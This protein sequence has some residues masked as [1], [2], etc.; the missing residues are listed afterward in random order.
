MPK[1]DLPL[2]DKG[3]FNGS[4]EVQSFTKGISLR[5][6]NRSV[7][8]T[9]ELEKEPLKLYM[10]A[11]AERSFTVMPKL[12]I[13]LNDFSLSKEFKPN[14]EIT[15]GNSVFSTIIYDISPF[16]KK[17]RNELNF[18]R[19]SN[20]SMNIINVTVVSFYKDDDLKT[21]YKLNAGTVMLGNRETMELEN[22][23]KGILVLGGKKG[24]AKVF[25]AKDVL[26]SSYFMES[27]ELEITTEGKLKVANEEGN[28][29][30]VFFYGTFS[31]ASPEIRIS[32][33]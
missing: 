21:D 26:T 24:S 4:I 8:Y 11:S 12:R 18:V 22:I 29:T 14:V 10:I 23:G 32:L 25:T 6:S 31:V 9:F 16:G 27:D 17:G 7:S 33:K 1:G 5:D 19:S 15:D 2:F 13:W 20:D 3:C 28:S 30:L